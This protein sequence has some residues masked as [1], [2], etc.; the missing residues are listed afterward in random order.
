MHNL[1]FV[2]SKARVVTRECKPQ[3]L[4][5]SVTGVPGDYGGRRWLPMQPF[6]MCQCPEN[7]LE[8]LVQALPQVLGQEP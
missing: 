7:G 2:G 8:R 1:T 3:S 4:R 5:E 6:T